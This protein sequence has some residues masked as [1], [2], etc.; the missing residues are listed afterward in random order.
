M[1][2]GKRLGRYRI[3]AEVGRG[4]MGQVFRATDEDLGRVVAVKVLP[5]FLGATEAF[6]ERFRREARTVAALRHPGIVAIYDVGVQ[7]GLHYLVME[8]LEGRSLAT[9]MEDDRPM[10]ARRAV[11]LITQVAAALDHAHERGVIHRD[12]K[13]ANVIVGPDD[14]ATLTDFGIAHAAASERLTVSGGIVGTPVYMSPE[15]ALGQTVDG[16]ADLYSLAVVLY[17]MLA[18][19]VPFQADSTPAV[20]MAHAYQDPPSLRLFEPSV[21]PALDAVLKRALAKDP[22]QRFQTGQEMMSAA[23][24]ALDGAIK[25]LPPEAATNVLRRPAVTPP[26]VASPEPTVIDPVGRTVLPKEPKKGRR[27]F[28]RKVLIGAAIVGTTLGVGRCA[29]FEWRRPQS[30]LRPLLGGEGREAPAGQVE[31]KPTTVPVQ[32]PSQAK[33]NPTSP[34]P[35]QAT[36]APPPPPTAVPQPPQPKPE[37]VAPKPAQVPPA[38]QPVPKPEPP[39][40]PTTPP[41]PP[42]QSQPAGPPPGQP[43]GPPP[44]QSQPPPPAQGPQPQPQQPPTEPTRQP[45]PANK[46]ILATLQANP[47]TPRPDG[48]GPGPGRPGIFPKPGNP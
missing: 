14:R 34:P 26:P 35:A 39:P 24:A 46:P 31:P 37:Q 11:Q 1:E 19:A 40:V 45:P 3:E 21:A 29:I 38:A 17:E 2:P 10:D 25:P 12:V 23:G 20:L 13:P 28:F 47:P 27:R 6:I 43:Q 41:S 16:R 33:P 44:G 22:A 30:I 9:V 15:Q 42:P 32:A 5:P 8:F 48:P 4:G 7:D 18:G 36:A